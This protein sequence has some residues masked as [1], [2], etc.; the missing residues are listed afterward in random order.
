MAVVIRGVCAR[1]AKA[2]FGQQAGY[3]AVAMVNNATSLPPF[4]GPIFSNP[5]DGV[6]F[7]VTIPFI[8]VRGLATT[9]TLGRRTGCARRR[10]R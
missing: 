4:E 6:P 2:I 10:D 5:D 8:G 7:T 1:V 9:A 3:A